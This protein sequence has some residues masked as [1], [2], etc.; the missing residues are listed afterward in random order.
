[1]NLL[2]GMD[3]I[4]RFEWDKTNIESIVKFSIEHTECE[5]VF[6]NKPLFICQN[7]QSQDPESFQ[8]LGHTNKKRKIFLS[9]IIKNNKIRIIFARNQTK[10]ERN[11]KIVNT[12][13]Y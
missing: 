3:K 7:Q 6:F 1:M 4:K 11:F 8:V 9:L 10:K 13:K 5:E 2:N 12:V